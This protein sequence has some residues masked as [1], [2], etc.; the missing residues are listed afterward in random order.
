V[1]EGCAPVCVNLSWIPSDSA[2]IAQYSWNLP[3]Q[4]VSTS[5][6]PAVCFESA[7]GQ[8]IFL[9]LIDEYGCQAAYEAENLVQVFPLPVARF[10][11]NPNQPD[12]I[13]PLVRFF[14]ES[15]HA[16]T[17]NWT[18]SDGGI[19][20]EQNP[21]RTF[22]DTGNYSA[23][24]KVSSAH[25]C[26]DFVCKNLEIEPSPALFVPTAFTPNGDGTNDVFVVKMM[27]IE[28]YLLEIFDRWGELLYE[29]TDQE[30]GWDGIYMGRLCQEDV[31]VWRVTYTD[32][33]RK[34]EQL[35]GRVTLI[36]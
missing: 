21:E 23:C 28:K 17:W 18:F 19:S 13:Q 35:I 25:G 16:V 30:A 10:S 11:F 14:D 12:I 29:T 36:E 34:S 27:Y 31:Y 2:N 6:N 1:T 7:G 9:N 20:F 24:L 33:Q 3:E 26:E 8:S 4:G 5:A 15:E 22:P 32:V